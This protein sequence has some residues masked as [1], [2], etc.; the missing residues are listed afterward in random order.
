[1][2]ST[3]MLLLAC[4]HCTALLHAI[5]TVI[6]WWDKNK[7]MIKWK[8]P[9]RKFY[10]YICALNEFSSSVFVQ[11]YWLTWCTFMVSITVYKTSFSAH[12]FIVSQGCSD[13]EHE[14]AC[15]TWI[16]M[17][18]VCIVKKT[19]YFLTKCCAGILL[20]WNYNYKNW[21]GHCNVTLGLHEGYDIMALALNEIVIV[22][23]CHISTT[24]FQDVNLFIT[25]NNIN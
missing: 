3:H 7:I 12:F 23:G 17:E 22:I 6:M 10:M 11:W 4:C 18:R 16:K 15:R 24:L 13:S 5:W 25:L 9:N 2:L 8:I 20:H 1:M 19:N 14:E 21:I